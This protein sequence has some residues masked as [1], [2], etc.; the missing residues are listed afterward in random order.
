MTNY[1]T[2]LCAVLALTG[3]SL[4]AQSQP[5]SEDLAKRLDALSRELAQVKGELAT[6]KAGPGFVPKE[7]SATTVGGYGEI[8]FNHFSKDSTQDTADIRRL[9]LGITHRFDERTKLVTELEVEHAVSSADDPGEVEVEQAFIEHQI[10]N[11]WGFRAGLF[12]MPVGFLNENHEPTAYYGVERNLVETAII[13][14]TWREG[15]VQLYAVFD[16][17]LTLQGGVSTGFNVT[18][19]DATSAESVESPLGSVHQ[20][21]AQAKSHDLAVFGALNWRGIPGFLLG[22]SFFTG[23]GG[24][25]Q[26]GTP[27]LG[28]S[29]WDVHARWNPGAFDLTA[30]FAQGRIQDTKAFNTPRVGNPYLVPKQFEGGYLQA[31]YRLPLGGTYTLAP[32]VRYE[33]VNTA[34]TFEDLGPGL[35]PEARKT[36]K[37]WTAGLNFSLNEHVVVK[38]D[39]RRYTEDTAQNRVSL[40]LGWSF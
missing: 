1:R 20:E 33:S 16:N 24:Q 25:G 10:G 9:V 30:L 31:A 40:G 5:S 23:K 26:A 2:T 8:V 12:L 35:T 36:D 21:M 37:V 27:D 17:G 4:F 7:A 28:V 6:V 18:K 19:W 13:P 34:K 38:A 3:G 15:G 32:F 29:L 39:V 14:T 11:T 22:G